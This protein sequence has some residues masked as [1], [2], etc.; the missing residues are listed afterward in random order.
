[1]NIKFDLEI[2]GLIN[3]LSEGTR[4]K[5]DKIKNLVIQRLKVLEDEINFQNGNIIMC[6]SSFPAGIIYE[7]FSNE[8]IDKMKTC[9][10][11][12]DFTDLFG[13][14]GI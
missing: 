6:I 10:T 7:G 13:R 12:D 14:L 3:S 11:E 1:M 8:L 9:V 4:D 2:N 5:L